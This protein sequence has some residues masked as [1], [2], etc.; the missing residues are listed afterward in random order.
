MGTTTDGLEHAALSLLYAKREQ[1]LAVLEYLRLPLH[2]NLSEN[3][4]TSKAAALCPLTLRGPRGVIE[5]LQVT[6]NGNPYTGT[7]EPSGH[8]GHEHG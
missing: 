5:Q 2:N 1:F 6:I 8:E 7:I 4:M 3:D